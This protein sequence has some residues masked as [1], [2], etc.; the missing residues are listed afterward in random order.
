MTILSKLSLVLNK[1]G[2]DLTKQ[3]QTDMLKHT[4]KG[5]LYN[6]LK[7]FYKYKITEKLP[8][9]IT[10]ICVEALIQEQYFS[11]DIANIICCLVEA[12][13]LSTMEKAQTYLKKIATWE[14]KS[15]LYCALSLINTIFGETELALVYIDEL[16]C[17]QYVSKNT[18]W[19]QPSANNLEI[20]SR[21]NQ[22]HVNLVKIAVTD[23]AGLTESLSML[24][25]LVS[26]SDFCFIMPELMNDVLAHQNTLSLNQSLEIICKNVTI[27]RPF[28]TVTQL[29]LNAVLHDQ[30]TPRQTANILNW[31]FSSDTVP[32]EELAK[33]YCDK[34]A[35]ASKAKKTYIYYL[36]ETMTSEFG[37][38]KWP[39]AHIKRC[40]L[41][42]LDIQNPLDETDD[43][44][45]HFLNSIT[46]IE[47]ILN[48][49]LYQQLL[50]LTN[51]HTALGFIKITNLLQGADQ[52]WINQRL[53]IR[54]MIDPLSLVLERS[55]SVF[56][57]LWDFK[58]IL[59]HDLV[60]KINDNLPDKPSLKGKIAESSGYS[61]YCSS[62][63]KSSNRFFSQPKLSFIDELQE[64]IARL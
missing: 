13:A 28:S 63:L 31:L 16:L 46:Q 1:L 40:I 44:I 38:Q 26:D 19:N 33:S 60:V 20:S 14:Y 55:S 24:N 17:D 49:A 7:Q 36:V 43:Y 22:L 47:A 56:H 10:S 39:L 15:S 21:L 2:I 51:M 61:Q 30:Q 12:E 50:P 6:S 23:D 3:Q 57:L 29:C 64:K 62:I 48:E 53:D 8:P 52:R 42:M 34:V 27:C 54:P 58:K 18:I 37:L 41:M 59:A 25:K 45:R 9:E 4:N 35:T 5:K 32:S 11:Q